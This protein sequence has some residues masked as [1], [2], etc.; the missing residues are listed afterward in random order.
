MKNVIF[1]LLVF[2]SLFMPVFSQTRLF[3][4]AKRDLKMLMFETGS[5]AYIGR[6]FTG[7]SGYFENSLLI[8]PA[9]I[10]Y[11]LTPLA[12]ASY[13]SVSYPV[14]LVY[15]TGG[16]LYT[17]ASSTL[18]VE[19]STINPFEDDEY[20]FHSIRTAYAFPLSNNFMLGIGLCSTV[21]STGSGEQ[22]FALMP[23]IGTIFPLDINYSFSE[24][25]G[26]F[27]PK[28][29]IFLMPDFIFPSNSN[30]SEMSTFSFGGNFIFYRND[31]YHIRYFSEMSIITDYLQIPFKNGF[32]LELKRRYRFRLGTVVP[33][34]YDNGGISGGVGINY[35][36]EMLKGKLDYSIAYNNR[37]NFD[38]YV[39]V[40]AVYAHNLYREQELSFRV[41]Y[42][43]FSPNGDG[44]K[45]EQVFEISHFS[46]ID[47]IELF[48][49][50]TT[51]KDVAS[52]V[53]S[54]DGNT[55]A[56]LLGETMLWKWDG[57]N[58][59]GRLL[60]GRY[61]ARLEVMTENG[62]RLTKSGS[63]FSID[64]EAPSVVIRYSNVLFSGKIDP[65]EIW[66]D[67]VSK[68]NTKWI[69]SIINSEGITLQ[70]WTWSWNELPRTI[71]WE[72]KAAGKDTSGDGLYYYILKTEDQAGNRFESRV[73]PFVLITSSGKK[74]MSSKK[75]YNAGDTT[76]DFYTTL[77]L[78]SDKTIALDISAAGYR[79]TFTMNNAVLKIPRSEFPDGRY[80]YRVAS[81]P[82]A[83][84]PATE[85]E[86]L[87]DTK[88]PV[89]VFDRIQYSVSGN[90]GTLKI[91]YHADEP[92][93]AVNAQLQLAAITVAQGCYSGTSEINIGFPLGDQGAERSM[94]IK[95]YGVDNCGNT[96]YLS[97]PCTLTSTKGD[98]LKWVRID[99][100]A[101]SAIES[102][103][104]FDRIP[105]GARV[106]R[107]YHNDDEKAVR[108]LV[109]AIENDLQL[110]VLLRRV[111]SIAPGT[112]TIIA[113]Y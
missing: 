32:E 108:P 93:S 34:V 91:E 103:A 12:Y 106:I 75:C 111:S 79:K 109:D 21:I 82:D 28:F 90:R 71:R 5:P 1:A 62:R 61:A 99:G 95:V 40:S 16:F 24:H 7:V 9:S 49:S 98:G 58:N 88:A 14:S 59:D 68:T 48:I 74:A 4:L 47:K 97:M 53:I 80:T 55:E 38:H 107:I 43:S 39:G 112:L 105:A 83:E 65:V 19:Y 45:D 92:V 57:I 73:G 22:A 30:V 81:I 2:V 17:F 25:I 72:G 102:K 87:I 67:P 52:F 84:V 35:N 44:V 101:P 113:E 6:G 23:N 15:P 37:D 26:I 3:A 31:N 94:T 77:A 85:G 41:H 76:I 18:G 29:G 64:I 86:F 70:D 50:D 8:N 78:A 10:G 104:V 96:G 56:E 66:H 100:L 110:Q 27:D 60:E 46:N 89:L 63:Q 13:G 42:S 20:S 69:G 51:G 11:E 54:D 36:V 33:D